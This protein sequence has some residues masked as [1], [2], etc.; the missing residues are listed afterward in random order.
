MLIVASYIPQR[1]LCTTTML[2][3]LACAVLV[4]EL[5]SKKAGAVC[6]CG[7]MVLATAFLFQLV[8]GSY[9]IWRN[10]TNF[11]AREQLIAQYIEEGQ[12]DLTLP[13]IHA[14]SPYSAFW[15]TTDLNREHKIPGRIR[16]WQNTMGLIP[17]L[18]IN[19][20]NIIEDAPS[21]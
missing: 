15:G 4:P 9:E 17:L 16:R 5:L 6:A 20:K 10:Y 7:C 8:T 1:C 18:G 12:T 11:T 3:I 14:T 19:W 2:L 21:E 13:C